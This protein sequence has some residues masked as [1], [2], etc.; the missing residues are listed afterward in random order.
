MSGVFFL[1]SNLASAATLKES[2]V[3]TIETNPDVLYSI[4]AWL[5]SEQGISKAKGGYF[6][7]IDIVGAVGEQNSKNIFTNFEY[8]NYTASGV[9]VSLNQL[10]FDGFATSNLVSSNKSHTLAAKYQV[11]GKANDI[12]LLATKAYLDVLTTSKI[13]SL[14]QDN[15]AMMKNIAN[16]AHH[17]GNKADISLAQ[18]RVA[19]AKADLLAAQNN[20]S[21]AN[22]AYYK[23]VGIE[24][25][26]LVMPSEPIDSSLPNN[27]ESVIK[28]AISIHP[29]LKSADA[30][31]AEALSQYA[32]SK[33]NYY[34]RVNAVVKADTVND[35]YG[36]EGN[37]IEEAAMLQLSY[38]VFQG[39]SDLANQKQ[40]GYL[41][42]QAQ[43]SRDVIY[44]QLVENAK[45]SWDELTTVK[46]QIGYLKQ[47]CQ[48]AKV[49]ALAYYKEYKEGKRSLVDVLNT[50]FESY[51]AKVSYV[52]GESNLIFS[53][54]WVLGSEGRLL[55]YFKI[56]SDV[57]SKTNNNITNAPEVKTDVVPQVEIRN[58]DKKQPVNKTKIIKK[59]ELVTPPPASL[60]PQQQQQKVDGYKV[61]DSH[62]SQKAMNKYTIQLYS[63]YVKDDAVDFIIKNHIQEKAA[64]YI[65][66]ENNRNKYVV[67]YGS[68]EDKNSAVSAIKLMTKELR[69]R[70]PV[71]K[72]L[73][74][75]ESEL[76]N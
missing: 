38:N 13:V 30:G 52:N 75:I 32:G 56:F 54:Y 26:N 68:Y 74:Q 50:Q 12:A 28:N 29:M 16:I 39:G 63:S 70:N 37:Q 46:T 49:S 1:Y 20:H 31:I 45:V 24:P 65:T 34:P 43:K 22:T 33:A 6:P 55:E 8:E 42:G 71:I 27:R 60:P 5:A 72:Q 44:N 67:V 57:T 40:A 69:T 23:I 35:M 66:K 7:K 21:D 17:R 64:F 59:E 47:H 48:S 10:V 41:V 2:I 4:K 61:K 51:K 73:S 3:R 11:V 19:L 36:I 15:Y 76:S 18:G 14:A 53:K 9:G 25:T 58:K 62:I